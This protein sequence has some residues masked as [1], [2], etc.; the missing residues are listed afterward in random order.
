MND[1]I[2]PYYRV[3]VIVEK[4]TAA[5]D[6]LVFAKETN[7]IRS[8]VTTTQDRQEALDIQYRV[9]ETYKESQS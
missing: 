7:A 5:G 1:R 8:T 3:R 6:G 9:K 2:Y 4:C